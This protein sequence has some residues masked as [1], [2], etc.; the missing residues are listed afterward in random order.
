MKSSLLTALLCVVHLAAFAQSKYHI[1]VVT[2]GHGFAKV[3]FYNMIDSL[4]NF[5]YD[6]MNSP[7]PTS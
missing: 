5:S 7:K 4:G 1:L 2:G 3:P 6:Q